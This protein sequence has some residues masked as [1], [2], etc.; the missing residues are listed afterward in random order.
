MSRESMIYFPSIDS[1]TIQ[2]H[3]LQWQTAY[4]EM[5]TLLLLPEAEKEAVP[6][7]QSLFRQQ[8][9]PLCGAIFPQLIYGTE[10]RQ[11]GVCLL[12]FD[13]MPYV[14]LYDNVPH[15]AKGAADTA[16]KIRL[17]LI[18][19]LDDD[20][21]ATLFLMLDAMLPNISTLLD[22][23]YLRL[24]NRVNYAGVNAGSE[25]FQPMPCL[26]DHQKLVENG[27]LALLLKPHQGAI[28]EHGYQINQQLLPATS[29]AGNRI[30]Q[31]D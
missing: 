23:I 7:L 1:E 9:I 19:Q 31:I 22:E 26:F 21:P 10:F 27:V 28:L 30:I 14:A 5:G 12:R 25:T 20:T 15:D 8:G 2:R 18:E 11:T 16:D 6:E 29:T 17:G 24:A 4:P 3:L 13:R